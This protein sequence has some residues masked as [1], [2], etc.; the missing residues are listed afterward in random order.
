MVKLCTWTWICD[1][2]CIGI[3][4]VSRISNSSPVQVGCLCDLSTT[5]DMPRTPSSGHI[6]LRS[7]AVF[8]VSQAVDYGFLSVTTLLWI[9]CSLIKQ[10]NFQ[11][12]GPSSFVFVEFR[13]EAREP[14]QQNKWTDV[15]LMSMGLRGSVERVFS[16]DVP[17]VL[18]S[19]ESRWNE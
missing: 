15:T 18:R 9:W 5:N 19:V 17:R 14:R 1:V 10:R 12:R 16:W 2:T 6:M 13:K 4:N 8:A 3:S 7:M 11:W